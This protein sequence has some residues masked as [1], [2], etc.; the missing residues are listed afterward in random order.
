MLGTKPTVYKPF[1]SLENVSLMHSILV[2]RSAED[3]G[4]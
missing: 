2:P 4:I 1:Q 3:P